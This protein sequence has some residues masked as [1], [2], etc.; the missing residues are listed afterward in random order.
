MHTCTL[1]VPVIRVVKGSLATPTPVCTLSCKWNLSIRG[2]IAIRSET[3]SLLAVLWNLNEACW[4]ND[5]ERIDLCLGN[6]LYESGVKIT[7]V[8]FTITSIVS[9]LYVMEN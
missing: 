4:A 1:R 5:L 9:L 3:Y 2:R 8:Y 6:V 7:Y